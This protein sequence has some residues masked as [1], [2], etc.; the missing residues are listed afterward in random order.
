M[1][2]EPS[3]RENAPVCRIAPS[4]TGKMHA[5]NAYAALVS[6][7]IAKSQGGEVLLRIEDLDRERSKPEYADGIMRDLEL[8]G[9]HWDRGP[10]FQ[11]DRDEAYEAALERISQKARAYECF[12]TRADIRSAAS[13]PHFGER[14]IYPGTCRDLGEHDKERLRSQRKA[15]IR[16]QVPDRS[17]GFHDL[18]QGDVSA[19]LAQECGD[20]ILRRS[21]GGFAYQL[22][23]VVD[24]MDNGVNTIVRGYDLLASTPGQAWLTELLGAKVP[25]YAHVPLFVASDGRRLAKRNADATI[26]SLI[27]SLG[28]AEAV[29]G[30]IAYMGRLQEEDV[31]QTP[32]SLLGT[33]DLQKLKE[34]VQSRIS[35]PFE[36]M[37]RQ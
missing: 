9:L 12:C 35:I 5:G 33:F 18:I 10:F 7:L 32:E 21:D 4:P 37:H 11:H 17:I 24:D 16:I 13:A 8:L 34:S 14:Q 25:D 36:A 2:D 27:G 30:H 15:A 6:W 3:K 31:P 23:V 28:S 19:N 26:E 22:A 20:F 1:K 29:L